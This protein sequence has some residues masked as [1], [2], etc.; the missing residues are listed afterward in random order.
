MSVCLFIKIVCVGLPWWFS[1]K[2]SACRCRKHQFGRWSRKIPH[3]A[4][5]LWSLCSKARTHN[6]PSPGAA[7]PEAH[8]KQ[9]QPET[10]TATINEFLQS[11]IQISKSLGV[12]PGSALNSLY[13]R[14]IFIVGSYGVPFFHLVVSQ[15]HS[16]QARLFQSSNITSSFCLSLSGHFPI[17]WCLMLFPILNATVVNTIGH[18]LLSSSGYIPEDDCRDSETLNTYH[19]VSLQSCAGS[20]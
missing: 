13:F 20:N 19:Q 1:G 2:E 3:A 9:P 15:A 18:K 11:F 6:L 5:Q 17:L 14:G 8:T 12:I 7:T 16:C 10:S 4:T